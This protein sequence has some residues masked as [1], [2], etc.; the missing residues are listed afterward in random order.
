MTG[1]RHAIVCSLIV[2]GQAGLAA[3][4]EGPVL[5]GTNYLALLPA[6][7]S[8]CSIE[9]HSQQ[10]AKIYSEEMQATLI[11]P[12]SSI[13][14][15]AQ[16]EL[17]KSQRLAFAPKTGLHVLGLI[18]GSNA[19]T[20]DGGDT[21]MAFVARESLPLQTCRE[22]KRLYFYVSKGCKRFKIGLVASAPRE[23]ARIEVF[24][25]GGQTPLV[26]EE[27]DYDRPAAIR[28]DVPK[29]NDGQVWSLAVVR[30]KSKAIHL[31][32]VKLWLDAALP[33]YLSLRADWAEGF[34]K[35]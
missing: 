22:L 25:P 3:A 13:M 6:A 16:P 32:D 27:D 15:R 8:S 33:P 29:G 20:V 7:G 11:G 23:G 18:A 17:G 4:G 31:D 14:A 26:A 24:S 30:P 9:L 35:R 2:L 21:P 5:R 34:G 10:I 28:V 19:C 1:L 12:D